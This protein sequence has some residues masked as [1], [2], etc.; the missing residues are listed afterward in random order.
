M[1]SDPV[2]S[3]VRFAWIALG[4]T[5]LVIVWGAVVR[6]TGSGA[7]CG[8]H[9]PLCNGDVVPL[10]PTVGTVIEFVHRLTSGAVM[11]LAV[12][13]VVLARRTFPA[14]HAVRTWAM[15]S[16]VFMMIEAAVG[17]GIVLLRLV[18]DNAS[19]LRAAYVG[20]HLVNTLLLVAAMTTTIWSVRAP[21]SARGAAGATRLF[22]VTMFAML[23]VAAT[24]AI[25]ALGD[26]LFPHAS[27]VEGLAADLDPTAHFLIR[28]RIWHPILAAAVASTVLWLAWRDPV[29]EGPEQETPRQ[30]VIM[31]VIGQCALGVLNLVLLA[32]LTLQMAHLL[33]SN[34]LWI[35]LV[36]AWRT[37]MN[38]SVF[39]PLHQPVHDFCLD[40]IARAAS[41]PLVIGLQA[42][43]GAGKTTL[44]SHLLERLPALGLRGAGV[45]VDDFYLTREEQ[46]RLAAAHPGNPYLEHRG[47]PGTHD[48]ALGTRTIQALR[49]LGTGA[50]A[51]V[52]VPVYDKS[53]HGGRGDRAPES[54]WR[55]VT[56][57]LD[58]IIVEG[59]MFGFAP[60]DVSAQPDAHLA[61]PNQALAAYAAWTDLVD[62]WV[63]LRAQ[64]PEYVLTWRVQA[65]EA[66]KASGKPGLSREAIEDYVRRFLPAYRTYASAERLPGSGP[67][68]TLTLDLER[69][70]LA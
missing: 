51:Q 35:P 29:F 18:E 40:Q 22:S 38:G 10:A 56:G 7:G 63:V 11:L 52:R 66:M 65:E 33:V 60:V 45:S 57:P 50:P 3:F 24:G 20:V 8:S 62:V 42:P 12:G 30:F 23:G 48:V 69:R 43:Q 41:R 47:Y 37:A 55:S 6:A 27:L 59:W 25:V 46:L 4:L 13:L 17:A 39:A 21:S 36:W 1:S 16:L 31:L 49:S 26:T 2:R 28:L 15:I 61:A 54:A 58:V 19:A 5:V 44:V 70:P 68:L 64:D 67:R 53:A 9:W 32:P 34:L 14:G